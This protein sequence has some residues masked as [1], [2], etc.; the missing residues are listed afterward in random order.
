VGELEA[1]K[2]AY[3]Q[4]VEHTRERRP[5]KWISYGSEHEVEEAKLEFREEK[6]WMSALDIV[7]SI[8]RK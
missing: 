3:D 8:T 4:K 5:C 7:F 6:V 1:L 2:R